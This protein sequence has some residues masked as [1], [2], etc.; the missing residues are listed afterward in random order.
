MLDRGLLEWQK[1]PA[2]TRTAK[3]PKS[4]PK[5]RWESN[6]PKDG[7]VLRETVRYLSDKPVDAKNEKPR[8]NFDFVWF[9]A[10]EA[11]Q[12]LPESPKV[13][14]EYK[15]PQHLYHR[16]ARHHLLNTVQ[17]ENGTYHAHEVTGELGVKILSV[18]GQKVRIRVSGSSRAIAKTENDAHWRARRIEAEILGFAVFNHKSA[19]FEKF[20]LVAKGKIYKSGDLNSDSKKAQSIG[21]YFALTDPNE[22]SAK[23]SPTHLYAYE[24]SWVK[25]PGIALHGLQRSQSDK[26]KQKNDN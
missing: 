13:G 26:E 22:P 8:F 2:K 1:L 24:G 6:Y 5:H 12:F 18:D 25:K 20:D 4:E 23:I 11:K 14:D 3:P 17:G 10:D 16:F 15:V 9:S 19:K 7:L 21:W